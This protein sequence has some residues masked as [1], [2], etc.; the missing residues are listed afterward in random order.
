MRRSS[1]GVGTITIV[2]YPFGAG[3]VAINLFL[4]GLIG[5]RIGIPVLPPIWALWIGA[6]L[7]L[8]VTWGFAR[9]IRS[10]MDRADAEIPKS[11]QE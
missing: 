8:P 1:W 7:G 10:L 2:L 9:H 11:R 6:L 3:A 4:L 5:P